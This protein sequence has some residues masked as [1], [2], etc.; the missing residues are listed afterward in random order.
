MA[1]PKSPAPG[2][3]RCDE[4]LERLPDYLEAAL[5]PSERAQVEAHLRGCAN[6]ADFGGAYVALVQALQRED[7]APADRR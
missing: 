3:L 2:G 5:P 6:C 7:A 1:D 4:V